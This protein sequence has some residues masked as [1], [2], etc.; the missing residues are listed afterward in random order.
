VDA[1]QLLSTSMAGSR[2]GAA[3]T[4]STAR[5][6]TG[7][8]AGGEAAA[9]FGSIL[10]RLMAR[11]GVG[12]EAEGAA[13]AG[14]AGLAIG[15]D[16]SASRLL[17]A[18]GGLPQAAA[19]GDPAAAGKASGE[20][21]E[22]D[23]VLAGLA[24][25]AAAGAQAGKGRGGTASG[26]PVPGAQAAGAQA[27]GAAGQQAAA[28]A[29]EAARGAASGAT[30][31]PD[32]FAPTAGTEPKA[33]PQ[34]PPRPDATEIFETEWRRLAAGENR[35][36]DLA[37]LKLKPSPG[38]AAA[39]ARGQAAMTPGEQPLMGGAM[40]G[41]AGDVIEQFQVL[42]GNDGAR[43]VM[44]G[45]D[46]V[47]LT[48]AGQP[49][50]AASPG[51]QVALQI[52]R[53]V[54]GGGDRITV[55]LQP[56]DLGSVEIRLD[57]SGDAVRAAVTVD[58]P[59]TLE[60]LQRD[61]RSLERALNDAGLKTDSGSLSFDL[62]GQGRDGRAGADA[63]GDAAPDAGEPGEAEP[64]ASAEPVLAG[65]DPHLTHSYAL[66]FAPGRLDIRI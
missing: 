8:A 21:P 37:T 46:A 17:S 6:A 53:S 22:A 9:E 39:L 57:F 16:A 58:R 15:A 66:R 47:G 32:L 40:S 19:D 36:L 13:G 18:S 34:A 49:G 28:A 4:G 25:A 31:D 60:L 61:A 44:R 24:P 38:Q 29:G 59:E 11:L 55:Q 1:I 26:T 7:P 14:R 30:G 51:E 10:G 50:A 20:A 62:R 42:T 63:D 33:D 2:D 52:Q 45:D 65:H 54:A 43:L 23:A 41:D 5:T 3:A 12:T 56:R 64:E 35:D 27:A 48:R